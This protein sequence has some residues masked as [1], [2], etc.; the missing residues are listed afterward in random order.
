MSSPT[1]NAVQK[2]PV[3]RRPKAAKPR[4]KGSARRAQILDAATAI[5]M[6]GGYN[7]PTMDDI[8]AACGI[9]KPVLYSHFS[10]KQALYEAALKRT[11]IAMS[12][13]LLSVLMAT[14]EEDQLVA[15]LRVLMEFVQEHHGLWI[16]APAILSG[17]SALAALQ[18]EHRQQVVSAVIKVMCSLRPDSMEEAVAAARVAP[19]A[20][21]LL[22]AADAGAS[23]WSSTPGVTIEEVEHASHVVLNGFLD[24]VRAELSRP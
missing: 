5:F 12:D 4:L 11:A 2:D 10:S 18:A 17:N 22:G 3:K 23:W 7:D 19:Y 20:H 24:M 1:D 13:R 6:Q 9:T 15:S 21:A 16:N 14:D 8:A